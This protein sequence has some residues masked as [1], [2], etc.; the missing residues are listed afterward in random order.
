[1]EVRRLLDLCI[2][3]FIVVMRGVEL[4]LIVVLLDL[5]EFTAL[6]G[7]PGFL[8][9]LKTL[10]MTAGVVAILCLLTKDLPV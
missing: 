7:E 10:V 9:D 8:G 5:G 2:L 6:S 3:L 4:L 1:M